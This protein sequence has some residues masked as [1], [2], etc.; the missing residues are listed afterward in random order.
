VAVRDC[1][2][3][4]R[5]RPCHCW[6]WWL[7]RRLVVDRVSGQRH[8]VGLAGT[9]SAPGSH[10]S[11]SAVA[12]IVTDPRTP[13]L[14]PIRSVGGCLRRS[15]VRWLPPALDMD[16]FPGQAGATR[17]WGQPDHHGRAMGL[18]HRGPLAG[19]GRSRSRLVEVTVQAPDQ[20]VCRLRGD[21]HGTRRAYHRRVSIG[22]GRVSAATHSGTGSICCSSRSCC[23]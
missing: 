2:G 12:A 10:R 3:R 8:A 16:G 18:A 5:P 4:S 11:T 20:L 21:S 15:L 19:D 13:A 23:R 14:L 7:W 22:P 6:D 9:F 1:G 17:R